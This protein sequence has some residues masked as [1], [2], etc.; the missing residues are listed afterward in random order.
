[1]NNKILDSMKICKYCIFYHYF[2]YKNGGII[3][4]CLKNSKDV[5]CNDTCKYFEDARSKNER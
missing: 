3:S 5:D 1:M 4:D 2:K